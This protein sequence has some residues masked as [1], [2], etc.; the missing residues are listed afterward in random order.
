MKDRKSLSDYAKAVAQYSRH[1]CPLGIPRG[2][3][4][5]EFMEYTVEVLRKCKEYGF[6]VSL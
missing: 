6:L 4:D 5:D 2:K 1:V 3:Y